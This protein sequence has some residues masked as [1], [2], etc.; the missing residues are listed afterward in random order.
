MKR[1]VPL[2][3]F[4]KSEKVTTH[5]RVLSI[6]KTHWHIIS[7]EDVFILLGGFWFDDFDV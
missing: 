6:K 1:N 5:L 3:A 7:L 4:G 2:A